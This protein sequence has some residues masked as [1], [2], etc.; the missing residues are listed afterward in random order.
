MAEQYANFILDSDVPAALT[1]EEIQSA[2]A[3]DPTLQTVIKTMN[4]GRWHDVKETALPGAKSDALISFRNVKDE[5]CINVEQNLIL[6]G[7][8]L[9][10]PAK[11]QHR[12]IQLAHEGHHYHLSLNRE[13]HWGT[14]DD[15]TTS[16]L[17]FFPLFST[18]LWDLANS[19]PVHSLT[20]SS[21]LFLCLPCLLPPFTVPC[22]MVLARPYHCSLRLFTMVRSSYDPIAC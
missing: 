20:L 18:V 14:T 3:Q 22:K 1:L 17:H 13:G 9:V 8:Q 5:L 4:T 11:L 12:V 6:K 2:T 7:T 19:R 16:F 15:Y 10:I 21:H